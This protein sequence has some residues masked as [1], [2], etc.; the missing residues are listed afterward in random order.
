MHLLVQN[1]NPSTMNSL[2][3]KN[4]VSVD[5]DGRIFD[6]DFNQQLGLGLGFGTGGEGEGRTVFDINSLDDLR[7][8]PI[9]FDN[10]CYGCTAGMGSS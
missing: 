1:F 7:D 3:C 10:H 9:R 8:E 5:Y 6:C 4:T 2:M